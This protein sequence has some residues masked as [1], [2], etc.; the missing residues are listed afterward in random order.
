MISSIPVREDKLKKDQQEEVETL[1]TRRGKH[2][3]GSI[4]IP[5]IL[6]ELAF[7]DNALWPGLG[8][9]PGSRPD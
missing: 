7:K 1:K 2:P 5:S 4:I 3:C 8:S 9:K 6:D